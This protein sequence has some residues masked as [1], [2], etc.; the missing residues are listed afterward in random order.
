MVETDKGYNKLEIYKLAHTLAVAV[1]E[2]TLRL[3]KIETYE[4]GSQIRRSSKSVSSNIVEGFSLRKY[5]N[6]FLHY[7][8]RAHGSS[9]ETVEHL[10]LLFATKSLTDESFYKQL[11]SDYKKLNGMIFR[12]IQ[13]I[14]KNYDTPNYLK[15]N[16]T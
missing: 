5:K 1:H 16:L 11:Y 12:F 15:E 7:L 8:Y 2:M 4:E 13:S 10:R 14:E 9:E 6:E 3:P